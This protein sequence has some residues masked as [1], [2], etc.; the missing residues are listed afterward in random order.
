MPFLRLI[1][2][3]FLAGGCQSPQYYIDKATRPYPDSQHRPEST[4]IQV[5]RSGT[6]IE[7][8]NS[9][10]YSYYDFDMWINQRYVRHVDELPA[11]RIVQM[12]LWD[13]YD[14]RGERFSAGGFWQTRPPIPVRMVEMQLNEVDP[15]I[16]LV[17]VVKGD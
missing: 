15:L 1:L 6:S 10:P 9:T 4:D 8:V 5:F 12:S 11:G 17:T 2:L 14:E 16:G 13:F 3:V 7:V